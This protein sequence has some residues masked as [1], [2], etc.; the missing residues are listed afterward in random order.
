MGT[1]LR[2]DRPLPATLIFDLSRR[3]RHR[4]VSCDSRLG[5]AHCPEKMRP[6]HRRPVAH[7][8]SPVVGAAAIAE[9]CR[10]PRSSNSCSRNWRASDEDLS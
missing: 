6:S 10:T 3:R 4:L 8:P 9:A 2:L 5:E 7:A 1:E